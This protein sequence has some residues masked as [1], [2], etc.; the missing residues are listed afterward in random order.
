L[1]TQTATARPRATE[2]LLWSRSIEVILA[3]QAPSGAY[4]AAPTFP[5][6]RYAWLRD[7]SFCALAMDRAGQTD[8]ARRFH[9][10]CARTILDQRQHVRAILA[11]HRRG[12]H[13]CPSDH[14]HARYTL[15]GEQANEPWGNFQ[16]DGYGTWLWALGAHLEAGRARGEDIAPLLLEFQPVVHLVAD[17]LEA[18]W[19]TPCFDCWEEYPERVHTSTLAAVYGGLRAVAAGPLAEPAAPRQRT[20]AQ[21][22]CEAIRAFVLEHCVASGHLTKHAGSPPGEV[23]A[24]LLW[25]GVPFGLL[26]PAAPLMQRTAGE[27]ESRL[28]RVGGVRRYEADTYYGGGEWLILAAWLAWHH[29]SCGDEAKAGELVGW[30]AAQARPDGALPEQVSHNLK[31]EGARAWWHDHWGPPACPLLWSHAMYLLTASPPPT[32]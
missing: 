13:V 18:F 31:D 20:R 5:P 19:P 29:Q 25:L 30:V 27:I 22:C 23:D 26:T 21:T 28:R 4:V 16:L 6:Y 11:R 15:S 24:S 9:R 10:W 14:L 2:D 8:S 1:S 32:R 17:Y 7:G 12:E 3:G